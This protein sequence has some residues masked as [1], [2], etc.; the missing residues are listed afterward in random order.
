MEDDIECWMYSG[1]VND[2]A[3][4]VSTSICVIKRHFILPLSGDGGD[5]GDDQDDQDEKDDENDQDDQDD[6]ERVTC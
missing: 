4:A 5:G 1:R 3:T 2:V 6:E